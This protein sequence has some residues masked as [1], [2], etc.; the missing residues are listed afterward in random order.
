MNKQIERLTKRQT[1]ILLRP[2]STQACRTKKINDLKEL[3][4]KLIACLLKE[5]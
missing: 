4:V 1:A 3:H 5:K 2:C